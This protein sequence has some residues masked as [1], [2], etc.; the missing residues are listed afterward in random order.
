MANY[1]FATEGIAFVNEIIDHAHQE[2]E[3]FSKELS[4]QSLG[5]IVK[6]V[7]GDQVRLV[8]RGSKGNKARAYFNLRRVKSDIEDR[9]LGGVSN[10]K[11]PNDWH[12]INDGE[13]QAN[14]I[15]NERWEFRKQRGTTELR[16]VSAPGEVTLQ[17]KVHGCSVD[18]KKDCGLA[19]LLNSLP[20]RE[21]AME[22][23]LTRIALNR[24]KNHIGGKK[25]TRQVRW[26]IFYLKIRSY[27]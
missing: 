25:Y 27:F 14:I 1:E 4:R 17:V 2:K 21:R 5:G 23:K 16:V 13:E 22:L 11:L 15:R 24:P 8:Q 3:N 12:I 20:L 10:L 26:V 18:L 19:K 6:D 9:D 7:F